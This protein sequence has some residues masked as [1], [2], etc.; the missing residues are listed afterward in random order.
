MGSLIFLAYNMV[1]HVCIIS[2]FGSWGFR[3]ISYRLSL[4]VALF[5]PY[6]EPLTGAKDV[7]L[8][9]HYRCY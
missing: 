8:D 5:E 7:V 4:R 3:R 9:C 6:Y 2:V 1:G